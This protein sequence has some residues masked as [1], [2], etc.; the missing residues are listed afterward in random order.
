MELRW[1]E[2]QDCQ[3]VG[4][5]A[6]C[7][8]LCPAIPRGR[9][10]FRWGRRVR[11]VG[12]QEL[13][14]RTGVCRNEGQS[15]SRVAIAIPQGRGGAGHAF[16]ARRRRRVCANCR[17]VR[18][19]VRCHPWRCERIALECPVWLCRKRWSP[20]T[21]HVSCGHGRAPR[22]RQAHG[23]TGRHDDL[24]CGQ[25]PFQ[26]RSKEVAPRRR[27]AQRPPD[28]R[29]AAYVMSKSLLHRRGDPAP[30][31]PGQTPPYSAD[32]S[33]RSSARPSLSRGHGTSRRR[34]APPCA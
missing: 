2:Y 23:A 18:R 3:P 29:A 27:H 13:C 12:G 32:L 1:G 17:N 26:L 10:R 8:C 16:S 7:I 14:G 5:R 6:R 15:A 9:L 34:Q 20:A 4:Q 28:D 30:E 11:R 19:R 33:T 22:R 24:S 31:S 21:S 25:Q